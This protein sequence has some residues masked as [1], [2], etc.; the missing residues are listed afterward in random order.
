MDNQH[1]S[2]LLRSTV[3]TQIFTTIQSLHSLGGLT[4]GV[5]YDVPTI[6]EVAES[7]YV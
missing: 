7:T 4:G 3:R 5:V 2:Y 6:I 1:L